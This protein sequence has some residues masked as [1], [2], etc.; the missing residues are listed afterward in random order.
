MPKYK[1]TDPTTGRTVSLTGD[2]PPTEQELEQIFSSLPAS[3]PQAAPAPKPAAPQRP[4]DGV[5]AQQ[6]MQDL[7]L[8]AVKGAANT[9]V[10]LGRLVHK[11]P[12]V[13]GAVDSLYGMFGAD[14]D[15]AKDFAQPRQAESRLGLNPANTAQK[16]GFIAE[17]GAE[18]LAPGKAVTSA[19]ARG[20]A[21]PR[22]LTRM[23][24]EGLAAVPTAL[25]QGQ[26]AGGAGVTGTVS[27]VAPAAVAGAARVAKGLTKAALRP[28]QEALET[29]PQLIDDILKDNISLSP[30]GVKKA[31]GLTDNAKAYAESLVDAHAAKPAHFQANPQGGVFRSNRVNVQGEI[32][33]PVFSPGTNAAGHANTVQD[34]LQGGRGFEKTPHLQQAQNMAANVIGDN[35]KELGLRE[36]LNLKRGEGRAAGE[37]WKGLGPDAATKKSLHGD[38]FTAADEALGRRIGPEWGAANA[39]TQRALTTQK[40]VEDALGKADAQSHMPNPYDQYLLM[41]GVTSGDPVSIAIAAARE[42]GRFRPLVA[43]VGRGAYKA[44]NLPVR[45]VQATRGVGSKQPE[46]A[47]KPVNKTTVD[48]LYNRY[49]HGR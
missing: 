38:L 10:G 27:A 37:L 3:K 31:Q 49:L 44:Q 45:A 14:V 36:V 6:H 5:A 1:V 32:V 48:A 24:G 20:A 7:A 12:G 47:N 15:S 2:S 34:V 35:P 13:S 46:D 9:A 43:D 21:N 19:L 11:I 33:D 26:S 40:V 23:A 42:A 8:G 30:E 39:A 22:L 18:Y 29:N 28:T 4:L 16:V 25:A 41:R 17:Q